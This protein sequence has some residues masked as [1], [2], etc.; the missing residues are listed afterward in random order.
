MHSCRERYAP[1]RSDCCCVCSFQS[2]LCPVARNLKH[3]SVNMYV[4]LSLYY[5]RVVFHLAQVGEHVYMPRTTEPLCCIGSERSLLFL[6]SM[7]LTAALS[8][9]IV[10]LHNLVLRG[11]YHD[12]SLQ[13]L[14]CP[15]SIRSIFCWGLFLSQVMFHV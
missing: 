14:I 2:L 15:T 9:C 1:L 6:N 4:T 7:T 3:F 11:A 8:F 12:V 13:Y 5:C 10:A